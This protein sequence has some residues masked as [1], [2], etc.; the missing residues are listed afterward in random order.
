MV[1]GTRNKSN[2]ENVSICIRYVKN[3]KPW[4]SLLAVAFTPNDELDA[5]SLTDLILKVLVEA[6]LDPQHILSQC[7]DGAS[8][9]QGKKG[10]M[11]A[12]LQ[13]KLGRKIPYVH[14]YNHRLHLVVVHA[15]REV[16]ELS[17]YFDQCGMLHEFFQKSPVLTMVLHLRDFY[18]SVGLVI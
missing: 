3:G 9:M 2:S 6:G 7:Y 16:P 4:E 5:K 18:L 13:N 11:Q 12:L 14:C 10:G 17:Q 8:V 1:D 15:I